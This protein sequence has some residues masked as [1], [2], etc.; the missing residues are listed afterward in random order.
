M[1]R[2]VGYCGIVCSDCPVLLAA[3]KDDDAERKRV[4]KLFTEEYGRTCKPEDINCEGCPSGSQH[5]FA[6]CDLYEIRRCG[7][8][9]KIENCADCL[10]YPCEKLG[11]LFDKYPKAKQTLDEIRGEHGSTKQ[12]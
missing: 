9:S 11:E 5:V 3:R 6:H 10:E 4:A 2:I 8:R 7:R 1:E 12:I